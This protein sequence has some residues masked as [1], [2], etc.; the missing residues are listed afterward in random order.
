MEAPT[1]NAW[2]ELWSSMRHLPHFSTLFGNLVGLIVSPAPSPSYPGPGPARKQSGASPLHPSVEMP[3]LRTELG[4]CS[5]VPPWEMANTF[6]SH[7][8]ST[9]TPASPGSHGGHDLRL[10]LPSCSHGLD[11]EHLHRPHMLA[12]S[13]L[14]LAQSKPARQGECPA[15]AMRPENAT[16][17]S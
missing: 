5:P 1:P 11:A 14:L 10:E 3:F 9:S 8:P 4:E 2:E 7:P 17:L 6:Q 16:D 15:G 13:L 12:G